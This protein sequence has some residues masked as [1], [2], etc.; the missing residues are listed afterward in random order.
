MKGRRLLVLL[1]LCLA[2]AGLPGP[3]AA[4]QEET[5]RNLSKACRIEK[6]GADAL[7]SHDG[8]NK[9]Y[10][11][12]GPED[13]LSI[14]ARE[15]MGA[16]YFRL[17]TA[18]GSFTAEQIDQNGAVL[19]QETKFVQGYILLLELMEGCAEV[20]ITAR[21]P[22]SVCEVQV[23]GPGT[24][25]DLV[26]P[27]P[28]VAETDFL[29]V[30]THPDDEWIF[31][32]AVYPI[33]GKERGY[34]GTIAYVTTPNLGRVHEAINST[35]AA[36]MPTL[37]YFLGFPDVDRAAP[38]KLKD[39]FQK[40][41]VTL[42]LVRLYRQIRPLVVVAQDPE[43]GEYGHWQHIISAQS[44]R[45]AALLAADESFDSESAEEFGAWTVQKV[46]Q[47]LA[48]ENPLE[49]DVTSPLS[50]YGGLSALE[51][52][53][54]AFKEHK[55]QQKY[56]FRPAIGPKSKGDIRFFGLTY[57]T[58]GPDTGNDMFEHIREKD[59]VIHRNEP[60]PTPTAA[61]TPVP[62]AA[63]TIAPTIAPTPAPE[64]QAQHSAAG[65]WGFAL[66]AVAAAGLILVGIWGKAFRLQ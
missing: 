45:E 59:L 30:T 38:R 53:K 23:Y 14:R 34:T 12:Y 29:I 33:Y 31:L 15:Q 43:K 7:Y 46:Y 35:W 48:K 50:A 42:A 16:L 11:V 10:T 60:T 37:P 66:A 19:C 52:A 24:L 51:V 20:R 36:G 25:P 58:L 41:E 5:A 40:E 27:E 47:H 32:G 49:L 57:S 44:A 1:C 55:S 39:T 13:V 65:P 56:V 21:E 9:T 3:I 18:E 6:N 17:G 28:P 4:G 64:P 61:A 63:P 62:T 8:N 26:L 2:V 54:L 22:L